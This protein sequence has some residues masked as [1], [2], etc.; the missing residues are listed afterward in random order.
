MHKVLINPPGSQI[1]LEEEKTKCSRLAHILR[2][3]YAVKG[4]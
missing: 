2:H 3:S 1:K 4:G